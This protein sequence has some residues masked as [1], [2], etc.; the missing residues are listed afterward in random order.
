[1]KLSISCILKYI[2]NIFLSEVSSLV[3]LYIHIVQT[4]PAVLSSLKDMWTV[5][6]LSLLLPICGWNPFKSSALSS[7]VP[8]KHHA[9]KLIWRMSSHTLWSLQDSAVKTAV[10]NFFSFI[11]ATVQWLDNVANQLLIFKKAVFHMP[12]RLPVCGMPLTMQRFWM[13]RLTCRNYIE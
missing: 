10:I 13:P 4:W 8:Y 2:Y 12:K 1:M 5:D 6:R 7:W 11:M 9:G 3:I